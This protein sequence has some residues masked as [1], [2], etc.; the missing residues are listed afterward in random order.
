MAA[1]EKEL[2]DD[3]MDAIGLGCALEEFKEIDDV[4]GLISTIPDI[5]NDQIAMETALER[6]L[7]KYAV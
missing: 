2:A 4:K 6:Y 1:D 3:G 5:Y 7:C